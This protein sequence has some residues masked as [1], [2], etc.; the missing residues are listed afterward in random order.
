MQRSSVC[1]RLLAACG[2]VLLVSG[3]LIGAGSSTVSAVTS[4]SD[5]LNPAAGQVASEFGQHV[6]VLPNG[7][8]VVTDPSY[9]RG[10]TVDVGAV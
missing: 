10:A 7:N 2:V 9:D 1:S 6:T 8:I 5:L 3:G 4:T